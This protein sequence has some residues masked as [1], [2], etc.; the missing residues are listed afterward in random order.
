MAGV[1]AVMALLLSRN[2]ADCLS[3]QHRKQPC[4]LNDTPRPMRSLYRASGLVQWVGTRRPPFQVGRP[5]AAIQVSL[6]ESSHSSRSAGDPNRKLLPNRSGRLK[7]SAETE[8]WCHEPLCTSCGMFLGAVHAKR[9]GLLRNLIERL[10]HVLDK[11]NRNFEVTI[12]WA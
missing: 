8:G 7:W 1:V 11:F 10:K 9:L 4:N 3:S 12:G 5:E 2:E 6:P